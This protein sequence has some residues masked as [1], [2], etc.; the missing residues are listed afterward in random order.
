MRVAKL[1]VFGVAWLAYACGGSNSATTTGG[2]SGGTTGSA[3]AGTTGD[4]SGST[5]GGP[6][7][8]TITTNFNADNWYRGTVTIVAEV[9][10][11]AGVTLSATVGSESCS[12]DS[13]PFECVI[14]TT[15]LAD[16]NNTVTLTATNALGSASTEVVV[17]VDNTAPSAAPIVLNGLAIISPESDIVIEDVTD[18][19]SGLANIE[20][21]LDGDVVADGLTPEGS[22]ANNYQLTAGTLPPDGVFPSG[23]TVFRVTDIAG[24]VTNVAVDATV[25]VDADAPVAAYV[26]APGYGTSPVLTLNAS[27]AGTGIQSVEFFDGTTL[28]ETPACAPI[29]NTSQSDAALVGP[30]TCELAG[31]TNAQSYT[32]RAVVKDRYESLAGNPR[33]TETSITFTADGSSPTASIGDPSIKRNPRIYVRFDEPVLVAQDSVTMCLSTDPDTCVE[34][35]LYPF[36]DNA[37]AGLFDGV[38]VVPTSRLPGSPVAT[39]EYLLDLDNVTDLAG[40]PTSNSLTVSLSP[41]SD[42]QP[43]NEDP[44]QVFT[45]NDNGIGSTPDLA[46]RAPERSDRDGLGHYAASLVGGPLYEIALRIPRQA[47]VGFDTQ[48]LTATCY[49]TAQFHY[50]RSYPCEVVHQANTPAPADDVFTVRIVDQSLAIV[51]EEGRYNVSMNVNL[52]DPFQNDVWS[53]ESFEFSLTATADLPN[54]E[55]PILGV[56][57]P[58]EG[59]TWIPGQ[60][61]ALGFVNEIDPSTIAQGIQLRHAVTDALIPV[62]Y[63]LQDQ[64]G[65][66]VLEPLS[67]VPPGPYR[68]YV[69][70][71]LRS[72]TGG[73]LTDNLTFVSFTVPPSDSLLLPSDVTVIP[74]PITGLISPNEPHFVV[75]VATEVLVSA[76]S[77]RQHAQLFELVG[78]DNVEVPVYGMEIPDLDDTAFADRKFHLAYS[79]NSN[80]FQPLLEGG[81]AKLVLSQVPRASGNPWNLVTP[82]EFLFNVANGSTA[83]EVT[84]II[85]EMDLQVSYGTP[86]NVQAFLTLQPASLCGDMEVFFS[87]GG[88][89]YG[90]FAPSQQ[91]PYD[92]C[93]IDEA[94]PG[95]VDNAENNVIFRVATG[96]AITDTSRSLSV[97]VPGT[98]DP[99]IS[100]T[101]TSEV[102]GVE[103]QLSTRPQDRSLIVVHVLDAGHAKHWRRVFLERDIAGDLNHWEKNPAPVPFDALPIYTR[104]LAIGITLNGGQVRGN[105]LFFG[106]DFSDLVASPAAKLTVGADG[107]E[108][109]VL[110]FDESPDGFETNNL[111]LSYNEKGSFTSSR[112]ISGMELGWDSSGQPSDPTRVVGEN[113]CVHGNCLDFKAASEQLST[114]SLPGS[115]TW[116]GNFTL[117]FWVKPAQRYSLECGDIATLLAT[118]GGPAQVQTVVSLGELGRNPTFSLAILPDCG[119]GTNDQVVLLMNNPLLHDD[120]STALIAP[121]ASNQNFLA[122]S[123]WA[124]IS[125]SVEPADGLAPVRLVVNGSPIDMNYFDLND[126][127]GTSDEAAILQNYYNPSDPNPIG[128]VVLGAAAGFVCD[129]SAPGDCVPTTTPWASSGSFFDGVI[130]EFAIY[131]QALSIQTMTENHTRQQS[132]LPL[133]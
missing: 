68:I 29:R 90:P 89:E 129:D 106:T 63:Q 32:I 122:L 98:D 94:V 67:A 115:V 126:S 12:D 88:V 16:G 59:G 118:P 31:L 79:R 85:T 43:V 105:P 87:V 83:D 33:T 70:S 123:T 34:V 58:T 131:T 69:R 53:N 116:N 92:P 114:W 17:K 45:D 10:V 4:T 133:P 15:E 108:T 5:T 50:E 66:V 117:D 1:W 9:N 8:P 128:H 49:V 51:L 71:E 101:S 25:Y 81:Q 7:T 73:A 56:S 52:P 96:Q 91:Q 23:T 119:T 97:F 124:H 127:G 62:N 21:V 84:P 60:P 24:N 39:T 2:T 80:D 110:G 121:V 130:D 18:A 109:W 111:L 82:V 57:L 95:I 20:L 36:R 78:D 93:R 27:D 22:A 125:L 28:I 86:N 113:N 14:D 46:A 13:A 11:P 74:P 102:I 65:V 120:A 44:L 61:I 40:N 76:I 37:A 35:A 38:A 100:Y 3:T 30:F 107:Q 48:Q 72:S 99:T 41:S 132:L 75:E 112:P 104:A 64:L 26:E 103:A 42:F 55:P 6:V 77:T 54:A 19:H 47:A